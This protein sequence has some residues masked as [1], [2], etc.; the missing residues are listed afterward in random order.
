MLLLSPVQVA[1]CPTA[2]VT[3]G[4]LIKKAASAGLMAMPPSALSAPEPETA[5]EVS[6]VSP[7]TE[8]SPVT[9]SVPP[10]IVRVL[11]IVD[12]AVIDR[13]PPEIVKGSDEVR[14]LI[15]SETL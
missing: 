6:V 5:P 7:L 15:E 14:L 3:V 2:L 11:L 8:R 4:P 12:A 9:A 1:V 10:L 13:L